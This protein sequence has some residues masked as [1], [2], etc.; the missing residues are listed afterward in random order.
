MSN[1]NDKKVALF[2]IMALHDKL[3]KI[4]KVRRD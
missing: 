4:N 1:R 3:F 2:I